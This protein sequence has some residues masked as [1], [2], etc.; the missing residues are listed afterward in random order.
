MS[1]NRSHGWSWGVIGIG[2]PA[3]AG[4]GLV[5]LDASPPP[6]APLPSVNAALEV[7]TDEAVTFTRDVAPIL[8]RA[9]QDCHRPGSVAP[10]SLL[11]YD[12]A[13][14][15]AP[16]IKLRVQERQ[17]PPFPLD[18]TVGIQ[19][20]KNDLRLSDEEI[21]I[22]SEWVDA[23]TPEGDPADLPVARE[24]PNDM[25]WRYE[26][27]YGRPPDL[28]VSSPAYMVR[29]TGMDQ[30][31]TPEASVEALDRERWIQAVEFRPGNPES[32]Y[33]FHHA[34]PSL[35][36]DGERTG[37]IAAAVGKVGEVFPSDAGKLLKPGAVVRFAMH[38]YPIREDVEAVMELGLW[39]YPDGEQ[40]EFETPGE[41]QH[42]ADMS[43][44][45]GGYP[46]HSREVAR[47]GDLVIPPNGT[48]MYRG[49]YVLDKP[50]RIH[51]LRGH[52]HLRGKYQVLEAIYPDGRWEII[53]KL[54][55]DH[56]WHTAFVYQDHV[57]PLLPKG[58]V[59]IVTSVFDNTAN[60]PHNPDPNQW[61][62][63]GSRTVDEMSHMWIGITY[64]DEQKDFD[65]LVAER[66]RRLATE[67]S[68]QS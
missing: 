24:W 17:M 61:V 46:G 51:S 41:V 42:R 48:A 22:I 21:E 10:L 5:S 7:A 58:T 66:E 56:A 54:D 57:Q 37:L 6:V 49:T 45:S 11:T 64:F 33:V 30:W 12:D 52:M 8:Q 20:F 60:N 39:F 47:R 36:Q 16:L 62:V 65:R 26:E 40:P 2:L 53:N 13:K 27:R 14:L 59:L 28:V 9:C 44:G 4:I 31:P 3:L 55:W 35:I 38:F 29:A 19:E 63:A 68:G 25:G 50:A 23:G 1:R 15:F 32:R 18:P 34:N 67:E 43:T